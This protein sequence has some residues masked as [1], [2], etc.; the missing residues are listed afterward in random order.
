MAMY[1]LIL[2]SNAIQTAIAEELPPGVPRVVNLDGS[3]NLPIMFSSHAYEKAAFTLLLQEAQ[4]VA[5]VLGLP[6]KK[7]ITP[8]DVI[9][10]HIN[11][12]GYSF[13]EKRIGTV[14]TENYH[15]GV[16]QSNKFSSLI[17]YNYDKVCD[18]LR[19]GKRIAKSQFDT[20]TP[21]R[22]A[23][24][25]LT[26]ISI[27]VNGLNRV[28]RPSVAVSPFWNGLKKLGDAPKGPQ[29]VPIYIVWWQ[30]EQHRK[31]GSGSLAFVELYLPERK[32]L[33][34]VVKDSRYIL[35]KPLTV[36]NLSELFP[37]VAKIQTNIPPPVQIIS[38]PF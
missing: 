31:E 12:F 18:E 2:A 7:V 26:A 1:L 20:K 8:G 25:W 33:Q 10:L 6:E 28:G 38:D 4:D 37:G 27:D 16:V 35:R 11:P 24:E 19:F 32:L 3:V 22:L 14:T 30:S 13:M 23:T 36:T 9:K 5:T 21:L 34:L 15:Y 29:F 17:V